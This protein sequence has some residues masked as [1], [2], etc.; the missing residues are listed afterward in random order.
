MLLSNTAAAGVVLTP[1]SFCFVQY[2]WV[3]R[4]P[5]GAGNSATGG[6]ISRQLV[7][8]LRAGTHLEGPQR[9]IC[10]PA[11]EAGPSF[12]IKVVTL[13]RLFFH[14]AFLVVV[15]L[16]HQMQELQPQ[17]GHFTRSCSPQCPSLL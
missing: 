7:V 17:Y 6:R 11:P 13:H 5:E 14:C 15:P 12:P 10:T 8:L 2:L 16:V 4:V 3:C 1:W 9:V